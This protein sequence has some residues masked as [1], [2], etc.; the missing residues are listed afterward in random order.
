MIILELR[1]TNVK[2]IKAI[3]IKP[4]GSMVK[5]TGVN[6]SGKS[7]SLDCVEMGLS[8]KTAIPS[9]PIRVGED[10]AETILVL[11]KK[12]AAGNDVPELVVKRHW[13]ADDRTYLSVETPEGLKYKGPQAALDKLTGG[14]PFDH[15]E[16][17]RKSARD[18]GRV[19]AGL[20]GIDLAKHED[21]RS[22]LM[23][24]RRDI[25]RDL[26][27]QEA[28]LTAMPVD[29]D[30]PTERVDV[31]TLMAERHEMEGEQEK[32]NGLRHSARENVQQADHEVAVH[33]RMVD[34]REANMRS[35]AKRL[36]DLDR[37]VRE[38]KERHGEDQATY[39]LQLLEQSTKVGKARKWADEAT[40]KATTL[41]DPDFASIDAKI[42]GAESV[43]DRFSRHSERGILVDDIKVKQS[44]SESF[45]VKIRAHDAD[46]DA[47]MAACNMPVDGLSICNGELLIAGIPLDQASNSE[48]FKIAASV[49]AKTNPE[50]MVMLVRNGAVLD[51]ASK[52]FIGELMERE[53]GQVWLEIANDGEDVGGFIIEDG[54]VKGATETPADPSN[55][56]LALGE[57]GE[58]S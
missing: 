39:Q 32:N 10:H 13:T 42:A 1:A 54:E 50:L 14:K 57:E 56:T 21:L 4:D 18:Q 33:A 11:G 26:K 3:R 52:T 12:D 27:Q 45:T 17:D 55:L 47:Q 53:G 44:A 41:T 46:L 24:Q 6:G 22:A 49:W 19:I 38:A 43:N 29:D 28:R 34:E 5:I 15:E 31:A 37:Q 35:W 30:P 9:R 7:S 23:D 8:G 51:T 40:A 36:A 20:A 48:R 25:N 2:G 58:E 16:F